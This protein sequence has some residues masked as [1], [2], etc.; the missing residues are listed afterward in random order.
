MEQ[1]RISSDSE[2]C[3]HSQR[4]S[5]SLFTLFRWRCFS[6]WSLAPKLFY[7]FHNICQRWWHPIINN[8][9][10]EIP[11]TTKPEVLSPSET[12]TTSPT[13]LKTISS[14][15]ST[16]GQLKADFTEF[17]MTTTGDLEQLKDKTVKQDHL[18][19]LQN[20]HLTIYSMIFLRR[21]PHSK[22]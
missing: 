12:L 3:H 13:R 10:A 14:M 22:K 7:E 6:L 18:I 5:T 15:R 8:S 19:K 21:L 17:H 4:S 11:S 2:N 16:L 20:N 9:D 1:I